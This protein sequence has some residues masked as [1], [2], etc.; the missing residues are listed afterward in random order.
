MA[1]EIQQRWSRYLAWA[2]L[3]QG[4]CGGH[5]RAI[6]NIPWAIWQRAVPI[7]LSGLAGQFVVIESHAR[8][9]L[10]ALAV[11]IRDCA[12]DILDAAPLADAAANCRRRANLGP[13]SLGKHE[14][15]FR[16]EA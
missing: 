6:Q 5:I 7:R 9:V 15:H 16:F 8:V 4:N 14:G 11:R 13:S 1:R 3:W 12:G 2:S 10:P